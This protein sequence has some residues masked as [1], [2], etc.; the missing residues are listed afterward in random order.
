M[1]VISSLKSKMMRVVNFVVLSIFSVVV[2][3]SCFDQDGVIHKKFTLEDGT[4]LS[5]GSRQRLI[6]NTSPSAIPRPSLVQPKRIVCAEPSPDVATTIAKAFQFELE[7]DDS[8][9]NLNSKST[10]NLIRLGERT[11]TIQLLR[12]QM[13]RACEAYANGAITGTTYSLIM[14]RVNKLIVTL[15]LGETA[16]G[17]VDRTLGSITSPVNVPAEIEHSQIQASEQISKVVSKSPTENGNSQQGVP[18]GNEPGNQTDNTAVGSTSDEIDTPDQTKSSNS[19][20]S[21][22]KNAEL[23]DGGKY[24]VMASSDLAANLSKMQEQFLRSNYIEEFVFACLVELGINSEQKSLSDP[25]NVSFRVFMKQYIDTIPENPGSNTNQSNEHYERA[26]S[27]LE[28][29]LIRQNDTYLSRLCFK[30]LP[31]L[32]ENRQSNNHSLKYIDKSIKLVSELGQTLMECAE[33]PNDELKRECSGAAFKVSTGLL[34][35]SEA[36]ST[37]RE[38]ISRKFI[39]SDLLRSY[40]NMETLR[41]VWQ[42]ND[43]QLKENIK[44]KKKTKYFMLLENILNVQ[45]KKFNETDSPA[46]FLDRIQ[47]NL[48]NKFDL[49]SQLKLAENNHTRTEIEKKLKTHQVDTLQLNNEIRDLTNSIRSMIDMS[50]LMLEESK[51]LL[52]ISDSG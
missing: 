4:S 9:L 27:E 5:V 8:K 16:S 31:R 46:K 50:S 51:S 52:A 21:V 35:S 43:T 17:A 22:N 32:L 18:S 45:R 44:N 48:M 34:P 12:D 40:Q 11:V 23:I 3:S 20:A 6:L 33:L 36:N 30:Q 15:M 42:N 1:I 19:N 41:N 2:L 7:K 10:E 37:T 39:F 49:I 29:A 14:S 47:S 25:L 24:K 38:P 13:Y 28:T 26:R